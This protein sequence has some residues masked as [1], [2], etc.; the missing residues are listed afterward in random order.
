M[1]SHSRTIKIWNCYFEFNL[2]WIFLGGTFLNLLFQVKGE[3][4]FFLKFTLLLKIKLAQMN[5]EVYVIES[6]VTR[7]SSV[8]R[9]SLTLHKLNDYVLS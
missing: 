8:D 5:F 6:H 2:S 1:E 7:G 9:D 3:K 4:S